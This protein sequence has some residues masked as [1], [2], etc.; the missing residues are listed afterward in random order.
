MKTEDEI[1]KRI[2]DIKEE[3]KTYP[4]AKEVYNAMLTA[5]EWVIE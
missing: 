4:P 5:L 3:C 1:L 2:E